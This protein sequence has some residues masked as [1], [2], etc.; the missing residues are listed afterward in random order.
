MGLAEVNM[1]TWEPGLCYRIKSDGPLTQLRPSAPGKNV[2]LHLGSCS[3]ITK[4]KLKSLQC[5]A[6]QVVLVVKNLPA[7]TEDI[8]D[9]G[10]I[11]GLGRSPREGNSNPLWYTC[12]R[13][14]KVREAWWATVN[15]A[16]KSRA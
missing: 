4:L 15:E 7:N 1:R 8:R 6:S 14:P 2:L 11:P 5:Q 16:A 12:L 3:Q 10:S 9:M 13:N